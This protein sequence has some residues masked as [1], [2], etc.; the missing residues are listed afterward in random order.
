MPT[1]QKRGRWKAL[2]SVMR[3][4]KAGRLQQEMAQVPAVMA[5][6]Y[7]ACESQIE[8]LV[9]GRLAPAK[10]PRSG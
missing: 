9:R 8:V 7:A 3:Y 10:P 6:H 5:K 4:E 2:K 1:V